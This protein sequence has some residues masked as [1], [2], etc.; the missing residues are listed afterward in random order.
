MTKR[1]RSLTRLGIIQWVLRSP[2]TL[3]GE[4][5]VLIP[6]STRLLIISHDHTDLN[7]SLF[8][9]IFTAMGINVSSVYCITTKDVELLSESIHCPCW[10]L[11]VDITLSIQG[12]SL[13]SPALN[14]LSLDGD[15]KRALWQ[16]IYH[17]EEYFSINSR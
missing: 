6:D 10:L 8:A 1:D 2:A 15:A 12:I 9:D 7:H 5:S 4:L 3:R 13:R 14:D 16:Q 11:G 17:Y